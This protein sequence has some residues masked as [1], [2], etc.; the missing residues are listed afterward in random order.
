M[1]VIPDVAYIIEYKGGSQGI[2]VDQNHNDSQ[3]EKQQCF[4]PG[5]GFNW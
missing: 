5:N 3:Q 4:K 1:L 2:R